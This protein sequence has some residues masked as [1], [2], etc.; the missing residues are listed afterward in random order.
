[1]VE[2]ISIGVSVIL[3]ILAFV[4]SVLNF[5]LDKRRMISEFIATN[6]MDW[7]KTVRELLFD[8]AKNYY[9]GSDKDTLRI[10]KLKIDMY[11]RVND[12][13]YDELNNILQKCID[14]EFCMTDYDKLIEESQFVLGAPWKR[15]KAEAGIS[16]RK[17][18]KY[19]KLFFKN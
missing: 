14:E 11:T 4:M 16:Q 10:C 12:P 9:E 8:F 6:R 3:S 5:S 1:M 2:N 13:A 15:M 17:D 18:V 7:I 19:R